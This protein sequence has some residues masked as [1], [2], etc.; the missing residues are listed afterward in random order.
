[1][2]PFVCLL[3]VGLSGSVVSAPVSGRRDQYYTTKYD[4][5][6]VEMILS[7][8]RLVYYYTA[9]ILNKGPCSPE[10]LEFKKLIP[11]ALRTNCKRCTEKQKIA[12]VQAIKGLMNRYETVWEQLK[13]EWDPDDLY[14]KKFLETHGDSALVANPNVISNRFDNDDSSDQTQSSSNS[15][16][17]R[18][19]ST[20]SVYT[21]VGINS[22]P[23]PALDPAIAPL[24]N[25][26][27]ESIRATVSFGN[28]IVKKVIKDIETIGNTVVTTGNRIAGNIRNV[29]REAARPRKNVQNI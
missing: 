19:E 29:V 12:T 5:V 14:V 9:C 13:A 8:R 20:T 15:T 4:H 10:G 11:D 24:A 2:V 25:S 16:T 27:G 6:D 23:V 1:M 21:N 3:V 26:I 22:R 18:I 28:N 7:N 17:T